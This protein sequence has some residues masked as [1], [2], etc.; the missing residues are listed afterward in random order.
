MH[1]ELLIV[2][3]DTARLGWRMGAGPDHLLAGGLVPRVERASHAVTVT[4]VN[5]GDDRPL[6][7]IAT[8]FE[9]MRRLADRV[10][11]ALAGKR[12]P[13]VVSGNCNTACGTLSGL[14]P[15][16]RAVF[17]FDAHADINTPDTTISGFLDGMALATAL[18]W[19]WQNLTATIHGFEPLDPS[20][21]VIVGGRD[22]DP[23][24]TLSIQRSR[25]RVVS[26]RDGRAPDLPSI[27]ATFPDAFGAY[28][29][30]DLDVLDPRLGQ[31][32]PFPAADGLDVDAVESA[33]AAIAMRM[34]VIAAAVTAYAPEYDRD[35]NVREAA[36][37]IVDAIVTAAAR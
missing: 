27:L 6:A 18:G 25:I 28:V 36:L 5:P 24:E 11:D 15:H 31:I 4:R 14:T 26:A 2:P 35:G 8:A 33:I 9:L 17:W 16:R 12:F 29:H 30:C 3:F 34:P 21:V 37:R 20:A 23:P 19:C 32:N 1:I 13:L 7:E 10:R 22:F